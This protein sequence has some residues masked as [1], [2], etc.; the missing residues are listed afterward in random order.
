MVR[1]KGKLSP[2]PEDTTGN[3][4]TLLPPQAF[5]DV[6]CS[7]AAETVED[8]AGER[9]ERLPLLSILWPAHFAVR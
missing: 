6:S 8:C 7:I 4:C 3:A 9:P 1:V 2:P 5:L